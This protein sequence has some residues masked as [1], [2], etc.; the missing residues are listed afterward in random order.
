M[1]VITNAQSW[2]LWILAP[3]DGYPD[4]AK[5]RPPLQAPVKAPSKPPQVWDLDGIE[6]GAPL[7]TADNLPV[8]ETGAN[9]EVV[10]RLDHERRL[11]Q[12]LP[13]LVS[14]RMPAGSHQAIRR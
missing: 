11:D 4:M 9:L 14:S 5:G 1:H 3:K 12:S 2:L 13:R 6:T 8:D 10:H 7:V